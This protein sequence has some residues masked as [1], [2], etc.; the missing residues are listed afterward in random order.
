MRYISL[1]M[2]K[3]LNIFEPDF[4][5][6]KITWNIGK[7]A[8]ITE[9]ESK[10]KSY[11]KFLIDKIEYSESEINNMMKKMNIND[12]DKIKLYLELDSEDAVIEEIKYQLNP[13]LRLRRKI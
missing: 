6:N 7:K 1:G 2:E 10:S 11:Q 5:S 3:N 13:K 4:I 8:G 12:D 9:S